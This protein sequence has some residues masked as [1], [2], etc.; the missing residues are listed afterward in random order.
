MQSFFA[1]RSRAAYMLFELCRKIFQTLLEKL[2]LVE[3]KSMCC[4]LLQTRVF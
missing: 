2:D 3:I 4:F 1:L